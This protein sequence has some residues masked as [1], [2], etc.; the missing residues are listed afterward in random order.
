M[1]D[2]LIVRNLGVL[3]EARI[4]PGPGLT[5]VTGETGAGKT[6]LLGALRMLLGQS[7]RADLIGPFGGEA[8]AEGRFL[9]ARGR[10]IGAGRRLTAGGRSRAYLDGAVASAAALD[11]ATAG[12]VEIVGQHDQLALTRPTEVRQL[13]DGRLDAE[14]REAR[15]RYAEAWEAHRRLLAAQ[16]AIGGDRPAL[17]R[18]LD[19]SRH[20]AR[21]IS[22]AG[23]RA[24]DDVELEI[25]LGRLRNA[26]TLRDRLTEA[27][28]GVEQAR[29]GLGS[30]V[31]A[32]RK[33]VAL[34]PEMA[35]VLGEVEALES[36]VG[37]SAVSLGRGAESLETE[38]GALDDAESVLHAMSDLRR[39]YGPTLDDVLA[40]GERA[41]RR[42]A[43]LHELLSRAETIDQEMVAAAAALVAVGSELRAAR[44][45]AAGELATAA[46]EHLGE[47]GFSDPLVEPSIA[48]AEPGPSGADSV[49]LLFASDRRLTPGDIARVASGGELSRLILSLRLAG[50]VG[51]VETLVFDEI[52]AGVGGATA[53][54]MG[55]KLAALAAARQV[56]CV[57]HLPQVAAF[58]DVHYVVERDDV[59]AGVRRVEGSHRREELARMLA[60]LPDSER[61]REAADELLALASGT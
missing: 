52:D 42:S 30:A 53:L 58:A 38:P 24:G 32:L 46:I 11:A 54:A 5:V 3:E 57:T 47:L 13:V 1:L 6:L 50:G 29:D 55:R 8:V 27:I 41:E 9:D 60:G 15:R 10:E 59:S 61:G 31:A 33:A 18:E 14:G 12:L 22:T 17:E 25:R 43:E 48:D 21:E 51:D 23:F 26:E 34:D 16:A 49:S 7:A 40:F 2:E 4:E 44:S 19:L 28:D 36:G 35:A 56:L 45:R 37:E 39:R 20:Q